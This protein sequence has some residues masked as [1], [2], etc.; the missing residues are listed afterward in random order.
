[1]ADAVRVAGEIAVSPTPGQRVREARERCG[2]TQTDLA[3]HLDVRR[4]SLSRIER[5]H[6]KPTLD[7][8][9]RFA[10]VVALAKH[11]RAEAARRETRARDPEPREF[12]AAGV[13]LNLDVGRI[14]AIAQEALEAYHDKR[15]QLLE[16][17]APEERE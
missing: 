17:V 15:R 4:E 11:V 2:F 1:M 5:G 3:P 16:D 7:V 14:E 8:L 13:R 10:R 6:A 9:S 12:R